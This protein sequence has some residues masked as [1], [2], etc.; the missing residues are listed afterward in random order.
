[1]K[2]YFFIIV[3]CFQ[4]AVIKAEY[5]SAGDLRCEYT[6][7]PQAIDNRQ[8]L[9]SW[10]MKSDTRG[11]R[12]TAYRIIVASSPELLNNDTGDIWDSGK[13]Q[14]NESVHIIYNGKS[15]IA[16][17]RYYW[18]VRI[19]N[20]DGKPS[21]W[22]DK[23][24]WS[25]GLLSAEDWKGSKWIAFKDNTIW[26]KEWQNHKETELQNLTSKGW[27]WLTGM[28]NTIFALYENANPKY[29]PSP[30]F[31]KDLS[32]EKKIKSAFLYI[33]GLGYYEAFIN[34]KK[35]GDHVLDPAW[36]NYEQR[37]MYST[38][39]VTDLLQQGENTLG[40]M[41]GRGQYNPLCNDVWGLYK[42]A[43][44]DQPK[45]IALMSIEYNDGSVSNI[46]TDNTWK[47]SGGPVIYDDT[48][49]GELYDARLEQPGWDTPEFDDSE[50]K[51][52]SEVIN[53]TSLVSQ[54][55]P[56][57]RCFEEI[58][59]KKT[60]VR[61]DNETIFDLGEYISGWADVKLTGLEGAKVLIEYCET[62]SD[63]VLAPNL[64]PSRFDYDIK[65][66]HYATFYDKGINVRQ[67]NGYILKG[68]GIETISCLFSYK[69]FRFIRV[70]CSSGVT[71]HKVTGIPVHTDV[72]KAGQ[73]ECSNSVIN[74]IQ[75]N[76]VR[77]LKCNFH[78]ISTDCPHR[79]KQGWTADIY[80]SAQAAMYNF[81]MAAFYSKWL[82][83]LK[84]TQD[85]NGGLCTV[86]PSTKYDMAVSTAWPAAIT[87]LPLDIYWFYADKRPM[88]DNYSAMKDFV[89]NSLLR[90][91]PGK[92]EIINDVLGDWCAP[93]MEIIDNRSNY[94]M[95]PPE[96]FLLYGTSSHFLT[97]KRLSEIGKILKNTRDA[98]FYRKWSDKISAAFN[99]EFYD[100]SSGIYHGDK[101]TEYRQSSNVVPLA[102]GLVPKEKEKSV[103]DNL[104]KDIHSKGDR[105]ATG[106]LGTMALMEYLPVADPELAYTIVTQKEY[107]GWGYMIEQGAGA[108]W[109]NW[110]GYS[111]RNHT[112]L[113][114]V[115]SYFYKY[116]S[117]IQYD[118][119]NLGFRHII[120]KPSVVNNLEYVDAYHDTLYGRIESSWKK[121]NDKFILSITIPANTTATV[122]I[123]ANKDD[124]ITESGSINSKMD[125][126]TF[127]G[128]SEGKAI[129]KTDS[130][131]YSFTV[132]KGK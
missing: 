60:I 87:Y 1:M 2:N 14:S 33:C 84:G 64:P 72:E 98:D 47:T 111:S 121:E 122:Y 26:K 31:R 95:P 120:I 36:T 71:L 55:M 125:N 75:Q 132:S 92:P 29:D 20:K 85:E 41:L 27:P 119:N 109:E 99:N 131:K 73:F 39:D 82:V 115:S 5:F 117:G 67:Q 18:K 96:G 101:P 24:Y 37:S 94:T 104:I 100:E 110:D 17:K 34:G 88:K 123:P 81:N 32:I 16:S 19:W 51:K 6:V 45:L 126:I 66:K 83:D 46:I 44:V 58:K 86:A 54:M 30:L 62:P 63:S 78:S 57:I 61:N 52:A 12:Q 13:T 22:S 10:I 42:S 79:E 48:R 11:D 91:I 108:M 112:P 40:A 124:V 114:L 76:A 68:Q 106:F 103:S 69:A 118:T 25:V 127:E 129:Y 65:D 53:N 43:W 105:P 4:I 102:Y 74:K 9:L 90:Q 49:Y 89:Q 59:P 8:P 28:D 116:L 50:W 80:M 128:W 35:V 38:Y 97:V 21:G 77:S 130:G 107:P 70:T 15:L 56:P 3:F 7:N 93:L 23:A 113:C